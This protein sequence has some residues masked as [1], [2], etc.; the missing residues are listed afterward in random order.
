[1]AVQKRRPARQRTSFKTIAAVY[2]ALTVLCLAVG[3]YNV[4]RSDNGPPTCNGQVM[5]TTDI[6]DESAGSGAP[7]PYTYDQMQDQQRGDHELTVH[8]VFILAAVGATV[9]LGSG[10]REVWTRQRAKKAVQR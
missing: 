3:F 5:A 6:C 2:G 8:I 10:V 7:F 9:I 4:G 1:M